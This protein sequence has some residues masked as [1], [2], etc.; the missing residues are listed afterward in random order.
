MYIHFLNF[1]FQNVTGNGNRYDNV[2]SNAFQIGIYLE[3]KENAQESE[4]L[5]HV[6]EIRKTF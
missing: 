5:S 4:T 6:A 2:L 3:G 1:L